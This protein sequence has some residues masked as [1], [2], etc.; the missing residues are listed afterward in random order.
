MKAD[1]NK[2][3]ILVTGGSGFIGS[4][5]IELILREYSNLTIFNVDRLTTGSRKDFKPVCVNGNSYIHLC[6]STWQ[7]GDDIV[8]NNIMFDYIFHFAAESHVDRSIDSPET[9]MISNIN[10]MIGVL[11]H[12]RKCNPQARMIN[13]STDEVYGHLG[14]DDE[15]FT[16]D[17]NLNPR[18]PYSASKASCDLIANA[19]HSTYGLDIITTR[20][21]NNF[22]PNQHDEKLIPTI[23]RHIVRWEK[24]PIYGDGKNVR[25]W[26]SV[27]DHNNSILE[28][29]AIGKSGNV[30]N[31]SG[32]QELNNLEM[33]SAIL[34]VIYPEES[35][36]SYLNFVR[37]VEDRK[38]HDIR[39]SIKSNKYDRQFSLTP[40]MISL[41]MTVDFYVGKY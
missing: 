26:I 8:V 36:D 41:K 30:Y 20:C 39:Y 6:L 3:T 22:G 15:P 27:D 37:F 21:C 18:S 33:V 24:V 28:I 7:I 34:Q 25:E 17:S 16:E 38:G 4:N 31:I 11:E 1:L 19:Y 2:K 9:F 10:G 40:F 35:Y 23:I 12:L 29:A 13:I 14:L 32:S 5:F